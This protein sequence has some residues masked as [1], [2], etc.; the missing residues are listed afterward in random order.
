MRGNERDKELLF[1]CVFACAERRKEKDRK[2]KT[3]KGL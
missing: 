1:G 2:R 3:E